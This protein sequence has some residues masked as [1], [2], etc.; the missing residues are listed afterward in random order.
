MALSIAVMVAGRASPSDGE[1][2]DKG[3]AAGPV[4]RPIGP[5]VVSPESVETNTTTQRAPKAPR[6]DDGS[7]LRNPSKIQYRYRDL[8]AGGKW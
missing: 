2:S 1:S 4:F 3:S 8:G 7:R 6:V 5:R